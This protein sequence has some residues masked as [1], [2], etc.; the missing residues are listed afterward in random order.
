MGRA[1]AAISVAAA[2]LALPGTASV[3]DGRSAMPF[4]SG[5]TAVSGGVHRVVALGDSVPSG[6]ACS[7]DPFPTVYGRLLS[8]R[9]GVPVTVTNLAVSGLDTAGLLDQVH[10]PEVA[11]TVRRSDVIL[12]T[13]GANDFADRHDQ[14]T[15]AGCPNDAMA[16]CVSDELASMKAH[17][18]QILATIFALRHGRPTSVLVTGY[19]NVFEDGQVAQGAFG[20]AGLQASLELT[21]AVNAAIKVVSTAAGADYVSLF[22]AFQRQGHDISALLAPDGDHPD[23]AGHRLIARTLV[24]AGLP[25]VS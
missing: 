1:T 20:T 7:C 23:T 5:T 8:R 21:L 17:L 14:V 9:T 16:D 11:R 19:W 10:Q 22:E 2:L 13:I 18:S 25:R 15:G 12:V 6:A 4:R 3:R 24:G